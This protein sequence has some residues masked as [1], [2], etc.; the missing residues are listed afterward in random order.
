MSGECALAIEKTRLLH[1]NEEIRANA[2]QEKLRADVLRTISHDL[3]TPL[4]SICG[5]AGM[6]AANADHLPAKNRRELAEAIGEDARYLVSMVENILSLTRLEQNKFMLRM[7]VEVVEDVVQEA[8]QTV[9]LRAGRRILKTEFPDDLLLA[10]MDVRLTIQVLATVLN[11]AIQHSG[12]DTSI[13]VRGFARGTDIVLEVA[14]EGSGISPADREHVFEMFYTTS[15]GKADGRRGMGIG[16]ALCR[17]IVR[18]MG[19]E[20]GIRDNKPC[21]TVF[22]FNL[23]REPGEP[24][25][26][27]KKEQA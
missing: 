16:L 4:T 6:L 5:N 13:T 9:R 12:P 25:Q 10:H 1:A 19:G 18:A 24:S 20:I 23:R 3:R 8:M 17:S 14:D 15:T 7:E 21:G 11:N 2:R 27:I 26:A 22:F